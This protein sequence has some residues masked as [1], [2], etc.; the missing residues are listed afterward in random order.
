MWNLS[1]FCT[2]QKDIFLEMTTIQNV[3][4]DKR[5]NEMLMLLL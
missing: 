1:A 3:K 5:I 2:Y 4:I